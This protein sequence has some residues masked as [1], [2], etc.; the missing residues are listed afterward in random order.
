MAL[1]TETKETRTTT[2]TNSAPD[3]QATV[4]RRTTSLEEGPVSGGMLA[5]RIVYYVLGVVQVILA[6]RVLLALLGANR[7]NAFV[8]F[9]FD[10]SRPLAQPFFSL[11]GYEPRYGSSHLEMGTL[12]AMLVYALLAWG[13]VSLIQLPSRHRDV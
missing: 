2:A 9:V 3:N 10:V 13:I 8:Q 6:M 1:E 12:V 7:S 11:F 4:T 5:S